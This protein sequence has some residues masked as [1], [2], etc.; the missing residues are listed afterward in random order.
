[1]TAVALPFEGIPTIW[2]VL[3]IVAFVV[4]VAMLFWTTLLYIKA[5]RAR[6]DAP[7]APADGADAFT[8]LFLVPALNEELTIRDSVAR[9]V[10]LPLAR[11]HIVVIDDGSDDETPAVLAEIEAPGLHVLR[12]E[13][14]DA[15][16][17]K[18]T[19]LNHAYRET[20]ELLGDAVRAE[21]IVVVVDADGRLHP[22]APRFAA[23][24]FAEDDRLGGV[25]SL[26]RIYNRGRLLT[27]LQDVEFS[28]YG[29]LYQAGRTPWGTA[30]MGGNGQFN[31][32]SALDAVADHE[33]PWR[34]RLTEDQD[35]G[36]RLV[37]AGWNG[38]QELRAAVDQ[39]GLPGL[40]RLMRQRTRWSQGNLQAMGLLGV[41]WGAHVS[42]I[43]RLD[44]V[45]YMLMPLWQTIVGAA[46]IV[47][48]A[49]A[50]LD[51]APFWGD[52]V[53][54]QLLFF[55]LLGFGGVLLGCIARGAGQGLGGVLRGILIAQVY[56]FYT[57]L[58]WPVLIRATARQLTDR[59]GWAKTEREKV[60]DSAERPR[61]PAARA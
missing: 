36:L 33:G 54:W 25:Q 41:V 16:K 18:A 57:W 13:P 8:W 50:I 48:I 7:E 40:R 47:A 23:P 38:R 52:L 44:L 58:L 32:L 39:Q 51:V 5:Q 43:A 37:G 12:R 46:L 3:F 53:W 35:L 17:G 55:Y 45:S 24:H 21:V 59:R 31:R 30:G 20:H 6:R 61:P 56:A 19:A 49:L 42:L 27:W 11:R 29:F 2:R 1:V 26:V 9:L 22:D 14:P 34:D 15:R 10:A 4:I 28:V 60:S